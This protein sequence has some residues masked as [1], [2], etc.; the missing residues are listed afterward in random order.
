[1]THKGAAKAATE[2]LHSFDIPHGS[3]PQCSKEKVCLS[4]IFVNQTGLDYCASSVSLPFLIEQNRI[5]SS[6]IFL[7]PK[8]R[9]SIVASIL[10]LISVTLRDINILTWPSISA[11]IV[12]Y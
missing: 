6:L 1:M 2:F 9:C 3:W 7:R 5:Q 11:D 4:N 8:L 12:S 10:C